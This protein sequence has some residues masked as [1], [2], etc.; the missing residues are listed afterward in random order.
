MRQTTTIIKGNKSYQERKSGLLAEKLKVAAY[1]RVSTDMEEQKNSYQTQ[2]DYYTNMIS[3]KSEWI[4]AGIYSDEAITGTKVDKRVGFLTMINDAVAGKIDMIITKSISRFARN[5]VDTLQYVRILKDHKVEVFFEEENI[6]TLSMDG[7]LLLT[8]LSSVA[9]QEVQNISEHVKLGIKHKMENGKMVGYYK[10]LGYDYDPTIDNLVI[11]EEEAEAVRF[12]FKMYNEGYGAKMI[13]KEMKENGLKDNIGKLKLDDKSILRI[14]KNEK[15][16][17]DLKTGKTYTVDPISKKRV[18]N[19]GEHDSFY[20]Q[21]HHPAI[22]SR[23]DFEMAQ[24]IRAARSREMHMGHN[25]QMMTWSQKYPLSSKIECGFCHGSVIRRAQ[26]NGKYIPVWVCKQSVKQKK[27]ECRDSK[28]AKEEMIQNAFVKM[29]QLLID[30][31]DFSVDDFLVRVE[32]TLQKESSVNDMEVMKNRINAYQSKIDNLVE[33]KLDNMINEE[34]YTRKFNELNKKLNSSKKQLEK[35]EN[36]SSTKIDIRKRISEFKS[37]LNKRKVM[38]VFDQ[39]IFEAMVDK[40]ILGGFDDSGHKD[41]YL[42]T[43]I[44][45]GG[46]IQTDL[47]DENGSAF[48]KMIEFDLNYDHYLFDRDENGNTER[49]LLKTVKVYAGFS[50]EVKEERAHNIDDIKKKVYLESKEFMGDKTG[51]EIAEELGMAPTSIS[52]YIKMLK[53][54]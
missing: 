41:P 25:G 2:V 13:A 49:R 32:E 29:Y 19:Y 47:S 16:V 48:M 50:N 35:L 31:I 7:E 4:F 14:L 30:N 3:K 5:T 24:V 53:E 34:Q 42:L 37:T 12:I 52:R 45:H 27:V 36:I 10:C 9:Q 15:Y 38:D 40:I 6:H 54:G 11:N 44:L 51:K 43:F 33:L 46:F 26:M 22:I 21:N 1:A 20:T 8:I 18:V 28:A 23:E 17:G 39:D